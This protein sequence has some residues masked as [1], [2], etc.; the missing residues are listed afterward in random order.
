M[1]I[2]A[3]SSTEN[4]FAISVHICESHGV[5]KINI[6]CAPPTPPVEELFTAGF[7]G[8]K[9]EKMGETGK[10]SYHLT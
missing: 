6:L 2:T 9:K 4:D 3:S 8:R 10:S 1:D 7:K 5:D